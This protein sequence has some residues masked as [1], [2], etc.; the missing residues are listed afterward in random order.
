MEK[1]RI[2]YI[3]E[4]NANGGKNVPRAGEQIK[5]EHEK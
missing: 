1:Q 5:N 2:K 3:L 4:N